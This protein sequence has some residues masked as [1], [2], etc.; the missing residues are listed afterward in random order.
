MPAGREDDKGRARSC[1]IRG[2]LQL[3]LR[4][5]TVGANAI[6]QLKGV[7]TGLITTRGH[8]DALIIIR[9]VGRSAGL[10]IE[11]LL[12]VSRRQKPALIISRPL[13]QEVSEQMDWKG[14]VFLPLDE[15]E[16]RAAAIPA[17]AAGHCCKSKSPTPPICRC[18]MCSWRDKR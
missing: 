9:S 15:D 2:I 8:D 12:H 4:G 7:K 6:V 5:T 1:C 10:P 14:E 18:G 13:I 11:K 3:L 17:R 16:T